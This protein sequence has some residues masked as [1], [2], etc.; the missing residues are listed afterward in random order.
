MSITVVGSVALDTIETP[1]GKITDGLG[2]SGTHFSVSA[3]FYT[4]V[5]LVGVVGDDFPKEHISMLKSRGI[6]LDGLQ[7][8]KGKTFRWVGKY[9][10]DLNNAQTLETHLN[11]FETFMPELPPAY[12]N[13]SVLFLANIDPDLQRHVIEQAGKPGFIALDTMNLWI[14]IKKESLAKTIKLVNLV[15]INEGEA[16]LFAGTPNLVKAAKDIQ[17]L[18]P[19]TVVIKQGEYGALLFHGDRVFRAPAMPLEQ[20]FDPTGA[21]DSFAGGLIGY[22]DRKGHFDD[23]ETLKTGV[24]CG[25]VMASF[26]VEKFSCD[27]L[28]EISVSDVQNRFNSF[29]GLSRFETI[30]L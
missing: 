13:P 23:F 3:G 16:R 7:I 10:F 20:V 18:G 22:L 26:N 21:G 11:V 25:S 1:F 28:L 29:E 17:A 15:T 12:R 24:V 27:R 9:D 8:A 2:G 14:N 30:M 4:Q 19:K 5:N 6:G